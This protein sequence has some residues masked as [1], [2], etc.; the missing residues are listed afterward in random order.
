MVAE[1]MTETTLGEDTRDGILVSQVGKERVQVRKAHSLI[2]RVYDPRNL[3]RAW[4]R[5]KEN[6]GAG[7][8]DRI[9]IDR[10]E[11][12]HRRYLTVLHQRLAEVR[13]RPLPVRRVEIDK[14]GSTAKRPL[15]IP[16]VVDRVCQQALRQ[17]LE[18]I[19]EPTFSE[20]SFGFRPE[21]SAH[22]AMRRIWGQMQEGGRWIVDADIADFFGT[23]SHD[24]LVALV[25]ERV[26][27]SK[28]L[29]LIRQILTAGVLRDGVYESTIAGT[30]Q[31]GV[32]SPLLSN[33][34]LHVFDEQ[35][36]RAGFQLTRYA[37]DW[38][39]VCRT[40]EEAERALASA[41]SVLEGQL[42]LRIHPEKTR[43]VHVSQGFEF[44]G[45][46][47]GLGRGLRFKSGGIGL[48]AIPR[49]RSIDRFK[50]K[51]RALTRRR[52]AVPLEELIHVLNPVIRG[53]GMYYR[54]ANVRRLFNRLNRWIV[55]RIWGWRF[56]RWRNAGW[57]TLPETRL[58]G[59]YGLVNLLQLIPSMREYYR[60][61]GYTH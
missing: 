1:A 44:L 8:V 4:A 15:G 56:K 46:K 7:G 42:G 19:F 9:S 30:P 54:R 47:I 41:R 50:D 27:D 43:I 24:R 21:R 26:A 35:M 29:S 34:Y 25:A 5:V 60:Q 12:E 57:R 20:V 2:G 51:A 33:I 58:Y 49:Q 11:R 40:R 38:L 3:A 55:R 28:V 23:I 32:I 13:Y 37:D 39:C 36:Q 22:M 17:V 10:F 18:P 59:E 45:Y 61:K 16:A 53:W 48:Y 14:P 6:R 31:G 52:I